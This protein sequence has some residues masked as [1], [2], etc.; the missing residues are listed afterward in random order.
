MS[1][2]IGTLI[3]ATVRPYDTE[4]LMATALSN[5]IYGGLHSYSTLLER[6]SIME[7]RRNWGMF[8]NV[9]DDSST[10]S[11]TYQLVYNYKNDNIMDNDNWVLFSELSSYDKP[12]SSNY[13]LEPAIDIILD[14]P[15]SPTHGDRY[16][17][18][19][20][21]SNVPTGIDWE[22]YTCGFISE[23]NDI[24]SNW[25]YYFPKNNWSIRVSNSDNSLYR[26]EG[27]YPSG[28]WV[29]EL[30]NQL[31]SFQSNSLDGINYTAEYPGFLTYSTDHF[32]MVT[33]GSTSSGTS[34]VSLNINNSG[35]K[36]IKKQNNSGPYED[37]M[38][39]DIL[40][41]R[42]YQLFYDGTYFRFN[43]TVSENPFDVKWRISP[44]EIVQVPNYNEYLLWGDLTVQ[45]NLDIDEY[46]KVVILNGS[47]NLDGGTVSNVGNIH[48]VNVLSGVKKFSATQSVLTGV[49]Y[50]ITHGLNTKD[51]TVDFWND[52]D[53]FKL[54]DVSVKVDSLN[55]I[56]FSSPNE[57]SSIRM[58]FIG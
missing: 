53:G 46:G 35:D 30:V 48:M 55:S 8:C 12:M 42:V 49:T 45:G 23:W 9:Y 47:L 15:L 57:I 41:G 21:S 24:K 58:V 3:T 22:V 2:N 16:I 11:G 4:D 31:I 54:S 33:F 19:L 5:E 32:Y 27:E 37:L 29:K 10:N 43:K 34:S 44:G 36:L 13:W 26:Y 17:I 18:G 7:E 39:G 28:R 20:D 51:L 38:V 25:E 52:V 50:S 56:S 40:P 1:Q 14:Q 6:D